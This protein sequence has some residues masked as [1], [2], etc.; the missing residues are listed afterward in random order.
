VGLFHSKKQTMNLFS[1]LFILILLIKSCILFN[2]N[3][4]DKKKGV[5]IIK[6]KALG[7][8]GSGYEF[9]MPDDSIFVSG[10]L[11]VEKDYRINQNEINSKIEF[12]SSLKGYNLLDLQKSLFKELGETLDVDSQKMHWKDLKSK[13]IGFNF[14]YGWYKD[15]KYTIVNVLYEGRKMKKLTFTS[16][17]TNLEY[18]VFL[19]ENA[20]E[21]KSP[22]FFIGIEDKFNSNMVKMVITSPENKGSFIFTKRFVKLEK[23]EVLTAIDKF[24]AEK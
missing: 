22:V 1:N 15:E 8:K 9:D 3:K 17:V 19:E 12:S 14:Y 4:I 18:E 21:N 24:A 2:N 20:D 16:K 13:E 23:H 5:Y 6:T 11:A 7:P 10:D